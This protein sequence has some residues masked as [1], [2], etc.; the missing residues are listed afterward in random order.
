MLAFGAFYLSQMIG[1]FGST[2]VISDPI[3]NLADFM[4]MGMAFALMSTAAI[5]AT[6][7]ARISAIPVAVFVPIITYMMLMFDGSTGELYSNNIPLMLVIL[8]VFF[9][10]VPIFLFVWWR[11]R[12][13]DSTASRRP[14]GMAMGIILYFVARLPPLFV[15]ATGV[16]IGYAAVTAS[17]LVTW[18]AITGRL[19]RAPKTE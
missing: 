16:H 7:R 13:T 5:H 15:L 12:T 11:I 1:L 9:L 8:V 4:L 14:L 18:L 6:G 10:P 17:F 3:L 19:S 2:G